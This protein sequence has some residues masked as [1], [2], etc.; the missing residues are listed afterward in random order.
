MDLAAQVGTWDVGSASVAVVGPDGVLDVHDDGH[1]RPWA[2]VTKIASALAVLDGCVEGVVSLDDE[3]GPP[4]STLRHLLAHASGLAMDSRDVAARVGT[5]RIYS[6]AGLDLAAEHLSNATGRPFTE[7]IG[8]RVFELLDMDGTEL[9]GP[10]AHGARGPIGDLARL[11]GELLAPR[12]LLGWVVD[13]ASTLAF[14]GLD[15]ILPGYGRQR[16]NDWGL[17]CEIRAEKSPH[18]TAPENSP[19]T[20]GHFGQSGSFCWVDRDA[21][22]ACVSLASERFG[23]WAI[24]AWPPFSSAV[25]AEYG[26]R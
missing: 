5:K 20:F 1:V 10:P 19:A 24:E 7:E 4:G 14:P 15:G 8:E 21:G 12:L 18:W 2:S 16:P 26:R 23:P 22:L 9:V 17:G 25:L 13:L 11:A 3:V 6:N